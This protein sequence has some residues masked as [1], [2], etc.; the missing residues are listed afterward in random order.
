VVVTGFIA[1]AAWGDIGFETPVEEDMLD[2]TD[3]EAS[4]GE[5]NASGLSR[6]EPLNDGVVASD[7]FGSTPATAAAPL[8]GSSE[9]CGMADGGGIAS[10]GSLLPT[11]PANSAVNGKSKCGSGSKPAEAEG[12]LA[13]GFAL[14]RFAP[15]GFST[16]EICLPVPI[17]SS[18]VTCVRASPAP[19]GV[20]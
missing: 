12:K 2:A 20:A 17:S 1:S 3:E 11:F 8:A 15:A 19:G 4:D 10:C 18:G 9:C 16:T 13:S 7:G 6:F 14:F 5:G